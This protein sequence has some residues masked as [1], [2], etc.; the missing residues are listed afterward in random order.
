MSNFIVIDGRVTTDPNRKKSVVGN[1][2]LSFS[3]SDFEG[4][5]T[6]YYGVTYF[7]TGKDKKVSKG[8]LVRID[9][10]LKV[11]KNQ[12]ETSLIINAYRVKNLESNAS[13]FVRNNQILNTIAKESA[14][15]VV[16]E[17]V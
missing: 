3:V 4:G 8:D 17:D 6:N 5:E 14:E 16:N 7:V 13:R 12:G 9:G 1:D 10:R 2:Y 15:E 11:K